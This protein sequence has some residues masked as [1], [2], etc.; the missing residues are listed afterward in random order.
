M[1]ALIHDLQ[2]APHPEGGFFRETYRSA[3]STAIFYLLPRGQV[4]RLHRIHADEVWHFYRGDSLELLLLFPDGSDELVLLGGPDVYQTV[5]PAGTWMGA[6]VASGGSWSLFG[7]TMA[8][9]FLPSDY[10]GG[11]PA[12][13]AA[14]HPARADRIRA[15]CRTGAAL[16]MPEQP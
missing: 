12:E 5:V 9:G 14:R 13:L 10:E 3:A 1:D 8:P 11:D 15:L 6:R 16:R 7:T 4:S 2:L